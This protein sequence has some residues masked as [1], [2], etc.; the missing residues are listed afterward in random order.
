MSDKRA[1]YYAM[2]GAEFSREVGD[3]VDKWTDAGIENATRHGMT[4]ERE[5]LRS[6]L[7][8]AM[9]A[10]RKFSRPVVPVD[11]DDNP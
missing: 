8:D 7:A 3:D 2:T 6:L 11:E 10:A 5:W 1:A 4:I 9:D